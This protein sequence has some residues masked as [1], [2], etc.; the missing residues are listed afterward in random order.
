MDRRVRRTQRAL[1]DAFVAL[2]LERGYE[3]VTVEDIAERADVARATFY[4]HFSDK[5]H[6]LT[7]LFSE[8]TQDLT[9][10]LA[11]VPVAREGIA[12]EVVLALY[13][14]AAEFGDIYRVSLRGAGN[15]HARAAYV[16]AI[17][18]ATQRLMAERLEGVGV[19]PRVSV[20]LLARAFAG[21]HVALV[22]AWLDEDPRRSPETAARLEFELL[23][24]GLLWG[25]GLAM[26]PV[27]TPVPAPTS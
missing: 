26:A 17:S 20:D 11:A 3:H 14:H 4:A 2:V 24:N 27:P 9:S 7:S 5:D 21:A 13:E 18:A 16:E 19:E 10:R 8:V 22:D 12:A 23:G 6:L 25:L 1:R 15:G